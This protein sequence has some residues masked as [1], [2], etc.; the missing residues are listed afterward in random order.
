MKTKIFLG[1]IMAASLITVSCSD[2]LQENPQGKLELKNDE[3]IRS[4]R[5][6]LIKKR[7]FESSESFGERVR[8]LRKHKEQL[9]RKYRYE[10]QVIQSAIDKISEKQEAESWKWGF[11]YGRRKSTLFYRGRT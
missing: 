7:W 3:N 4:L 2:L 11:L 6:M 5:R 8:E 9:R 1:C 10:A